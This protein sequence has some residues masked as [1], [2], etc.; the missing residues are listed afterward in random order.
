MLIN[1]FKIFIPLF[2]GSIISA[3]TIYYFSENCILTIKDFVDHGG[4]IELLE[5]NPDLTTNK[6]REKE[7]ISQ[8]MLEHGI[9]GKNDKIWNQRRG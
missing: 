2:S 7:W 1:Y 4:K 8:L 9:S 5:Q 3:V 6:R